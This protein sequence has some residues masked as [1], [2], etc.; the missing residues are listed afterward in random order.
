MNF[1]G[2]S[3]TD[4]LESAFF[5]FVKQPKILKIIYAKIIMTNMFCILC[6]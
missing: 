3:Y 1:L 2:Y 5:T 6:K 4:I